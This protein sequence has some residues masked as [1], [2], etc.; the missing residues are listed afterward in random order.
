M[1]I[2]VFEFNEKGKIEF[3]RCELEKLLNEIYK[4]GYKDGENNAKKDY[5]TWTSPSLPINSQPFYCT[6]TT[7]ASKIPVI[8]DLTA[9]INTS[10][11]NTSDVAPIKNHDFSTDL[12]L[13][14][15]FNIEE[16]MKTI[17]NTSLK[18]GSNVFVNL[19]K[20]LCNL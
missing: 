11:K 20:E 8:D 12:Q 9:E 4:N 3:T 6:N 5:W 17:E 14:K 13:S 2:R 19:A 7:N 15:D 10:I 1:N 16:L 18:D